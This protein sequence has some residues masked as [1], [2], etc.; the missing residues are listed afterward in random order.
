MK[1]EIA[2][3]EANLKKQEEAQRQAS[4]KFKSLNTMALDAFNNDKLDA[5]TKNKWADDARIAKQEMNAF[6]KP[7]ADLKKKLEE[8]TTTKL[9]AEKNAELAPERK[10]TAIMQAEGKVQDEEKKIADKAADEK[11]KADK[12]RAD[13]EKAQADKEAKKQEADK[14]KSEDQQRKTLLQEQADI[15]KEGNRKQKEFN[16]KLAQARSALND[17]VANLTGGGGNNFGDWNQQ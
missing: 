8:L 11:A 13:M 5:V 12:L 14:K 4:A 3:T 17:W 9:K 15:T 1:D 7:I 2:L 10:K 6:D 16:D